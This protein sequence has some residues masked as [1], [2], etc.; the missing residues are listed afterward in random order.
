MF[1]KNKNVIV[2]KISGISKNVAVRTIDLDM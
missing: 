1:F 2:M